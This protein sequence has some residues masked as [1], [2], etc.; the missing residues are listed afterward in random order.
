MREQEKK[1]TEPEN[2]EK[3]NRSK[4]P[5]TFRRA[6]NLCPLVKSALQQ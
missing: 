2:S 3:A 4:A 5:R 6:K 1:E